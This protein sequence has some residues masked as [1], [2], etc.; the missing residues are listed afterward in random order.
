MGMSDRFQI[1]FAFTC[2]ALLLLS[3][4]S[5]RLDMERYQRLREAERYQMDVAEKLFERKV[6]KAARTEFRKFAT[7]YAE[8]NC[9]PYC[10]YQI[11]E[12]YRNEKLIN[13]AIK[14]YARVVDFWPRS[15]DSPLAQYRIAECHWSMG[16]K[17]KA[18]AAWGK[19]VEKFPKTNMCIGALTYQAEYYF[20]KNKPE[21]AVEK[22]HAVVF[23]YQRAKGWER[24]WSAAWNK[25]LNSYIS[26]VQPAKA[27]ETAIKV[28]GK[29]YGPIY[30][31]RRFLGA[32]RQIKTSKGG[33][34]KAEA[35]FNAA[36]AIYRSI[37]SEGE[38]KRYSKDAAREI[39]AAL[40]EQGM[41]EEAEK[42]HKKALKKY[43]K[44][45]GLCIAYGMF[46]ESRQRY[47]EAAAAYSS[48]QSSFKGRKA[49]ADMFYRRKM[50]EECVG[51]LKAL[52]ADFQAEAP[53][54][55]MDVAS[56]YAGSRQWGKASKTYLEI[57]EKFPQKSDDAYWHLGYLH[58][59]RMGKPVKAIKYYSM[60][61]KEPE[62]LFR[63]ADCQRR[64]KKYE[65]GIKTL[66]EVVG[67]FPKRA[68]E[69]QLR[70]A[71]YFSS[72]G[73]KELAVKAYMKVCD[74]YPRSRWAR[75]AHDV[76]ELTYKIPYTGGGVG[77]TRNKVAN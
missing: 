11:A 22:L 71:E 73:K 27:V 76:L 65:E 62:S 13:T 66:S 31:A 7:L 56:R 5:A 53:D 30:T 1:V 49:V 24:A 2:F 6:W 28:Y 25:L 18:V 29:E 26:S 43:P 67:F 34:K 57:I 10:R 77:K 32:G 16:E 50:T 72:W 20:T 9:V 74:G 14:E 35:A 19:L 54:I 42:A 68:A 36:S 46:L 61:N 21:I 47:N 51:H 45:D 4:A 8:S 15:H 40:A 41:F 44:D 39:G 75:T 17:G 69:A 52:A 64:M 55:Y 23:D 12:C 3:S 33:K 48:C 59:Y 38:N 58:H 37:M 63:M 70:I 60:S